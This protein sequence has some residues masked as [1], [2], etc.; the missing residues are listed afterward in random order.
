[1]GIRK[2]LPKDYNQV[3]GL[4][5][6]LPEMFTQRSVRNIGYDLKDYERGDIRNVLGCLVF[7][8]G[9][10][11]Q[12]ALIYRQDYTGDQVFE[13]KWL[14]VKKEN[15]LGNIG[16]SLV[17]HAESLLKKKARLIVLYTSNTLIW[18][19]TKD[20]FQK[21]GYQ[22][23]AIIPDFWDDGDDRAVFWKRMKPDSG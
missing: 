2:Y 22:K 18:S 1:M 9:E 17:R 16:R 11:I 4:F 15:Q 14:A 20:F 21:L 5:Q 7:S 3:V 6:A 10:E 13:L 19:G 23:V 8:Q 12:G